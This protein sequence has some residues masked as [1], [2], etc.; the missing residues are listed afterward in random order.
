MKLDPDMHI[1][2][3]LVSFGK[4]GVTIL[5]VEHGVGGGLTKS[6]EWKHCNFPVL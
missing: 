4:A 2:L 6:Y 1:G 3:H 5:P